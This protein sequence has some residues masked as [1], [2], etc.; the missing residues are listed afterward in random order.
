MI[1]IY[2]IAKELNLS[3]STVS[4]TF[5]NPQLVSEKT[6]RRVLGKA[7]EM[8]YKM[9]WVARQLRSNSSNIIALIS[10]Q[11]EWTAYTDY[12]ANGVQDMAQELGYEVIVLNAGI[13]V[14]ATE[15]IQ[16]CEQMR[17]AGII[18]GDTEMGTRID[19]SDNVLPLVY[20]NRDVS[21]QAVIPDDAYGIRVAM[22]YLKRMGHTQI[23]YIDGP[24]ESYHSGVRYAAYCSMLD[25]FGFERND[26]WYGVGNWFRGDA[27]RA[28]K[29][30]A[31]RG[32]LP[33]AFM[34]AN[35]QMCIGL[36]DFAHEMHL[37]VGQD[38]SVVGYD[39]LG[40][41][42]WIFPQLTTVSFPLYEMGQEAMQMLDRV[43]RR[44]D[45]EICKKT[46]R[47]QLVERASVAKI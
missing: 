25:E 35:D 27:Y 12:L 16:L 13:G 10:V 7:E 14:K 46:V 19:Y 6:K 3:P 28:V 32:S 44:E 40:M 15:S 43:I 34:V 39:D 9:N 30:I 24:A 31:A 2:D 33:T 36:Y 18:V 23:G 38:I 5:S 37:E 4:R 41:A 45:G 21:G 1:T 29:E 8:G 47:G 17:F 42:E 26:N 11:K 20:V 22:E